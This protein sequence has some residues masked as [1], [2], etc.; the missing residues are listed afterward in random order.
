MGKAL[1]ILLLLLCAQALACR[2]LCATAGRCGIYG[3]PDTIWQQKKQGTDTPCLNITRFDSEFSRGEQADEVEL[4]FGVHLDMGNTASSHCVLRHWYCALIPCHVALNSQL[5]E[6]VPLHVP[7][8]VLYMGVKCSSTLVPWFGT[9]Y[10]D[11]CTPDFEAMMTR[12][13]NE[14]LVTYTHEA[15][16]T[17]DDYDSNFP[18]EVLFSAADKLDEM[19]NKEK[20]RVLMVQ[21]AGVNQA[22]IDAAINRGVSVT[23]VAQNPGS[24]LPPTAPNA[25]KVGVLWEPS[26]GLSRNQR[27]LTF[28]H[29]LSYGNFVC[30]SSNCDKQNDDDFVIDSWLQVKKN[31]KTHVLVTIITNANSVSPLEA[32]NTTFGSYDAFMTKT[33]SLLTAK[34][35][36]KPG[37]S[38]V[39]S[40]FESFFEYAQPYLGVKDTPVMAANWLQGQQWLPQSVSDPTIH[41]SYNAI[42]TV[43]GN[44]QNAVLKNYL[45]E[46]LATL[47]LAE[48]NFASNPF[49][50][51]Y[52]EAV[53]AKYSWMKVWTHTTFAT[54][55]AAALA[56]LLPPEIPEPDSVSCGDIS[57]N[58][59][60]Q[61]QVTNVTFCDGTQ[62]LPGSWLNNGVFVPVWQI[63]YT[64]PPSGVRSGYRKSKSGCQFILHLSYSVVGGPAEAKTLNVSSIFNY[65]EEF[66][67]KI[68]ISIVALTEEPSPFEGGGRIQYPDGLIV[69][70]A[71]RS[72]EPWFVA[73]SVKT[74]VPLTQVNVCSGRNFPVRG[75]SPTVKRGPYS[76]TSPNTR[77]VVVPDNTTAVYSVY[78]NLTL[79]QPSTLSGKFT[80]Y[81]L[82]PDYNLGL[83][84]ILWDSLECCWAVDTPFPELN[85]KDGNYY[86]KA[87]WNFSITAP[88]PTSAAN[89]AGHGEATAPDPFPP[90]LPMVVGLQVNY[91]NTSALFW[92]AD[93]FTPYVKITTTPAVPYTTF[94]SNFFYNSLPLVVNNT[95]YNFVMG[96]NDQLNTIVVI[97][98]FNPSRVSTT[99]LAV[100]SPLGPGCSMRFPVVVQKD[101]QGFLLLSSAVGDQNRVLW[102]FR[103]DARLKITHSVPIPDLP[104]YTCPYQHQIL[105][106]PT[107]ADAIIIV[108][109]AENW[110]HLWVTSIS[111]GAVITTSQITTNETYSSGAFTFA[112]YHDKVFAMDYLFS[113]VNMFPLSA[114]QTPIITPVVYT[115]GPDPSVYRYDTNNLTPMYLDEPK[116]LIVCRYVQWRG[117]T[118][119]KILFFYIY[120]ADTGRL[121]Q[122][123][124]YNNSLGPFDVGVYVPA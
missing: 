67:G 119:T 89:C 37:K 20:R 44:H 32:I 85:S 64:L 5:T 63:A 28:F 65:E 21:D 104:P 90:F 13:I 2:Q 120:D 95:F 122:S 110:P 106:H 118:P 102:L 43:L 19:F 66:N 62:I 41:A 115:V 38:P 121:L 36:L 46:A 4:A 105:L 88:I 86:G 87:S 31:G 34:G 22:I 11:I 33:R 72:N 96:R 53:A 117:E 113:T 9:E 17:I 112:V 48:H 114:L 55:I 108:E 14:T 98:D 6:K 51:G 94:P 92:G 109:G 18:Y 40:T 7:A 100:G 79:A 3:A 103:I 77:V 49:R 27:M 116:G 29:P 25:A 124:T 69:N 50:L 123:T 24:Y 68:D 10:L 61:G 23:L 81:Q 82:P 30:K 42:I 84:F 97:P 74:T 70:Y 57:F 73:T 76:V 107:L 52:R 26:P 54:E 59:S 15:F 91:T 60:P 78:K 83:S 99:P 111:T 58:V 101:K 16:F 1:W 80:N 56:T 71:P 8:W 45:P 12:A 47:V 93:V 75:D 39:V 35:I